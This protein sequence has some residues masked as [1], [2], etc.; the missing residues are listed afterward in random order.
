MRVWR[1]QEGQED[2]WVSLEELGSQWGKTGAI[3]W[4]RVT[5]RKSEF[6]REREGE[7][8]MLPGDIKMEASSCSSGERLG[9]KT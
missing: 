3:C 8:D 1:E 4:I 7:S 6:G 2:S 5:G 9:P